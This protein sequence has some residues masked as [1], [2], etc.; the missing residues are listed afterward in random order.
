VADDADVP[1]DANQ[2]TD[3]VCTAGVPFNPSSASGTACNQGGQVCS[4]AGTCVEC[5]APQTCPGQD[6]ECQA[7]TC[8][9]NACGIVYATAGK[10][11]AAQTAGDCQESQCDGAGAVVPVPS[12]ADLP[13]DGNQ[14]TDDV[15]TAGA[16]SNPASSPGATC[17]QSGGQVCSGAG[18]CVECVV[19]Q[20]CPGQNTECQYRTCVMNAC[21]LQFTAAGT[22]VMA[23]TAGDC[24]VNEC[25]GAGGVT[26][27][28]D[29]A[30]VP[31]DASDCTANVCTA[32]AAS[33]PLLPQ[34]TACAQGGGSVCTAA[35]Q[36]VPAI[37]SSV[38]Y[39]I[40]ALG[41][42]LVL[43]GFGFT[44]TTSVTVGGTS[45]PSFSV[46]SDTQITI[47]SLASATLIGAQNVVVV[48]PSGSSASLSVT[49][50]RL[51]ISEL[52]SDTAGT[53][54]LEFVEI[55]TGVPNVSLAGY[56]LVFFDGAG[57]MEPSYSA[58]AL[59]AADAN[60][61][62]LVGNPGV[63]PA[64]AL[65]FPSNTLQD[66]AD[67]VGIYQASPAA[68]PSNTPA[69]ST[70]L[71]DALV[72]GT[73]DAPDG[74]LFNALITS[75]VLS[76]ARVQVDE[77]ASPTPAETQ[78]IQRCGDGRRDGRKFLAGAPPTPGAA[79]NVAACP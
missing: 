52:D 72:Y 36:C 70:G 16:P 65:T 63:V 25:N 33:N 50:I 59:S 26:T 46:D 60:G 67:A 17:D 18:T 66:G 44:G 71:I 32:G 58:I 49:V 27:S 22:D 69:T 12:G 30:D 31:V 41:G 28:V 7:R 1:V 61:L 19:P 37:V 57:A 3:D 23:Q 9:G 62:L 78:S 11:V 68:F 40:I 10:P 13:V 15:C 79:N 14:C 76:Q 34:G 5:V 43:T 21:G 47:A 6:T 24:H 73:G 42:R 29:D 20:T 51:Q 54:A 55:S 77:G 35:G 45:Q 74:G 4:G 2:C 48:K 56:T 8:V 39:P 53:D 38:N 64:P 75:N